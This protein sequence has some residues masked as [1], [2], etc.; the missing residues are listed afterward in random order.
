MGDLDPARGSE[1]QGR[2]GCVGD[3]REAEEVDEVVDPLALVGPFG[4]Q[5][6]RGDQV[7]PES[8]ALSTDAVAQYDVLASREAHEQLELLERARETEPRPPDRRS[9]GDAASLEEHL[10]LLR[11]A[12]ARDHVEQ[13]GLARPVRPDEPDD[14]RGR[15]GDAYVGQR[16]EPPETDRDAARLENRRGGVGD[17]GGWRFDRGHG[18][19]TCAG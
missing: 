10:P 16:D 13:R 6:A 2:S 9:L 7:A 18:R 4:V 5:A 14:R 17:V 8:V 11:A 1:R 3:A 15:H 19:V 12:K